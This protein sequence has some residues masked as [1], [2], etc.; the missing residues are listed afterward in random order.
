M[1]IVD[2]KQIIKMHLILWISIFY[3]FPVVFSFEGKIPLE[4]SICFCLL[5]RTLIAFL[6]IRWLKEVFNGSVYFNHPNRTLCTLTRTIIK[7]QDLIQQWS[8]IQIILGRGFALFILIC[9]DELNVN[10]WLYN[11][12]F[13]SKW[14]WYLIVH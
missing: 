1:L 13:T 11:L 6:W 7:G 14:K 4:S 9:F 12:T 8:D 5:C 2:R 10:W 3:L